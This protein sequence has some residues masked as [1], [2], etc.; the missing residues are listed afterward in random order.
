MLWTVLGTLLIGSAFGRGLPEKG[1]WAR[2]SEPLTMGATERGQS[3]LPLMGVVADQD[4]YWSNDYWPKNKGGINYR[5]NAT[6]P[7]GFNLRSPTQEEARSMSAT[8]LAAL[9]PTEKL[10]LLSSNYDYPLK[11]EVAR[12]AYPSA[13]SWEG[14]CNGWAEAAHNHKEPL[15]MTVRNPD[16]IDIPFGSSDIKA[17]LSWYYAR[18]YADGYARIGSRCEEKDD[19][20]VDDLNAG[21]FHLVL[22]NRLGLHGE[23]FVADIDRGKEVWN[24][25]TYS[26]YS[27]VLYDNLRPHWYSAPGTK[28]VMRVRTVVN[29]VFLLAQNSWEPVLGTPAQKLSSRTYEYYLD[30]DAWGRIIGGD[31]ISFQRPD[32]LWTSS[33]T[34]A[35]TG[36]MARL[37]DLVREH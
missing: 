32:F 14:I 37:G 9:A 27:S 18:K 36:N 7:T 2:V 15:P 12:Y 26:Y 31:W 23:G 11:R 33:R 8:E 25:L 22:A 16:G 13:P 6:H 30:I 3:S 20:C 34:M 5:W 28:K 1:A 21:A 10:D 24:H 35:F 19:S 17:L 29:Y 4:K